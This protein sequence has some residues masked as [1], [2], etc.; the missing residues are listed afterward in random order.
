MNNLY[1]ELADLCQTLESAGKDEDWN[2]IDKAAPGLAS[3]FQN[4]IEYIDNL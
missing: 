1:I 2:E 3:T 4:V